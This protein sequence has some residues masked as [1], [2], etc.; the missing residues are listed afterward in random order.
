VP[1]LDL[2][3]S[4]ELVLVDPELA[5]RL[6]SLALTPHWYLPPPP[7][8]GPGASSHKL[9][10]HRRLRDVGLVLSLCLNVA[11]LA[12][13]YDDETR[14]APAP[15]LTGPTPASKSAAGI[16]TATTAARPR[17]A[18]SPAPATT[19]RPGA[20]RQS[21]FRPESGQS[22]ALLKAEAAP[23][24]AERRVLAGLRRD[25]TLRRLFTSSSTEVPA[26]GVSAR[27]RPT[28]RAVAGGPVLRCVVWR[29]NGGRRITSTLDYRVLAGG[30]YQIIMIH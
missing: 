2:V 6:R 29:Q 12:T 11:V 16:K 25:P 30:G 9:P 7:A 4:P 20:S 24:M 3:V 1:D 13:V 27:C 28:G 10:W 8:P 21:P 14:T 26:P 23:A 15:T 19:N 18:S 22:T 5:A 17:A